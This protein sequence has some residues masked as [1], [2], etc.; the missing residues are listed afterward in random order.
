MTVMQ[1]ATAERCGVMRLLDPRYAGVAQG[2][3]SAPI[4]GKVHL[5]QLKAGGHY[6]PISIT[7]IDQPGDMFLFGLDNLKRHQVSGAG[8]GNCL[9][10]PVSSPEGLPGARTVLALHQSVGL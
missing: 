1:K 9:H 4:L 10:Q 5:A 2:V 7:V 8:P 6:V 3:G